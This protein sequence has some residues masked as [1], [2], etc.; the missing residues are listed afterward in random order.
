MKPLARNGSSFIKMSNRVGH[1][2]VREISAKEL[3]LKR[4]ASRKSGPRFLRCYYYYYY[5]V[6]FAATQRH[7]SRDYA[8]VISATKHPD[9][10][11]RNYGN[12]DQI[13]IETGPLPGETE[14][15]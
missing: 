13:S 1:F 4:E 3:P 2:V 12:N 15:A 5:Y 6:R 7:L 9:A 11:T 14:A 8:R 10:D